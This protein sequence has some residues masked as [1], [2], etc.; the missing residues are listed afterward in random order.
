MQT[1]NRETSTQKGD[2]SFDFNRRQK[3][4]LVKSKF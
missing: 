2:L 1:A 3:K 4:D